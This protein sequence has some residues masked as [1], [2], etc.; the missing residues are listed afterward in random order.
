VQFHEQQHAQADP[1]QYEGEANR[2]P[3]AFDATAPLAF[4]DDDARSATSRLVK[5]APSASAAQRP[6]SPYVKPERYGDHKPQPQ[7]HVL[8]VRMISSACCVLLLPTMHQVLGERRPRLV[9]LRLHE[10]VNATILK[11]QVGGQ[12]A[13]GMIILQSHNGVG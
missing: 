11:G 3:S 6:R 1:P 4:A 13:G 8:K 9:E 10:H 7:K 12:G 5:R 2:L